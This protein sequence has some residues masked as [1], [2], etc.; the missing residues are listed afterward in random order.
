MKLKSLVIVIAAL[1]AVFAGCKTET[2]EETKEITL[3][4]VEGW[5]EGPAMTYVMKDML[6]SSGYSVTVQKAAVDL[7]FASMARGDVD[8]F[9]DTWMPVTHGE[10]VKKFGEKIVKL[11]TNYDS[12][13][14]GLVVPQYVT[15]DSIT[16]LNDNAEKFNGR[17]VGIDSGAGIMKKTQEAT[18][19]Y[20]LKLELMPSSGVAML[21]E[22][23]KAIGE[24]NWIVVT[25]WSPHFKFARWELKYLEDP[26]GTYGETETIETWARQGLETDD[27]FAAELLANFTLDDSQMSDLLLKMSEAKGNEAAVAKQWIADNKALVDSFMPK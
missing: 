13:R 18:E 4:Y 9:M 24:N 11:G 23:Q 2:A 1:M 25:G 12:A 8:A 20:G 7:I 27:P 10:K 5:A 3:A 6:E 22:L 15:I 21:S 14:I 19:S 16:E 26:K 17:I